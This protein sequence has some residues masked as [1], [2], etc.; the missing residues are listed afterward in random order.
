MRRAMTGPDTLKHH[1]DKLFRVVFELP[2]K[3]TPRDALVDAL[4]TP[5]PLPTELPPEPEPEKPSRPARATAPSPMHRPGTSGRSS[6]SLPG[7]TS[8]TRQ[9]RKS[10]LDDDD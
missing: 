5:T 6:V 9:T 8:W 2:E 10:P 4:T 3:F 7:N 1:R